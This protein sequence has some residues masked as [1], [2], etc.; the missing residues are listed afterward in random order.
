MYYFQTTV[1]VLILLGYAKS[2][3]PNGF[4]QMLTNP[5][6]CYTVTS[7]VTHDNAQQACIDV[8]AQLMTIENAFENNEF[9]MLLLN[10]DIIT[11][12]QKERVRIVTASLQSVWIGYQYNIST[13]K[14]SWADLSNTSTYAK[15]DTC[16]ATRNSQGPL[17]YI[18]WNS[19]WYNCDVSCGTNCSLIGDY[20]AL[21][22]GALCEYRIST[23]PGTKGGDTGSSNQINVNQFKCLRASGYE[24]FIGQ[25]WQAGEQGIPGTY[26]QEGIN[27]IINA[28]TAGLKDIDAY[29]FPCGAPTTCLSAADQ[30]KYAV[31]NLTKAGG[32]VDRI[33][34]DVETPGTV[35]DFQQPKRN[36]QFI[37]DLVSNIT[38]FKNIKN[39]AGIYTNAD[40]WSKIVG[41]WTGQSSLPLFWTNASHRKPDFSGFTPFGGWKMPTI[42]QYEIDKQHPQKICNVIYDL[43]WKQ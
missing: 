34:V 12:N 31:G 39:G 14:Y 28:R 35:W 5:K 10:S 13:N 25:I 7:S 33:W 29:I 20:D 38:S 2:Q 4:T 18:G 19:Y 27:N 42:R 23:S 3:C 8:G 11:Q 16:C 1:F 30:V 36:Q 9:I 15:V 43:D 24:F 17:L 40:H 32:V 26:D 21:K 22:L 6:K 41:D 37:S